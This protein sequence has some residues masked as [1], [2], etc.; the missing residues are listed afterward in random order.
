M[1]DNFKRHAYRVYSDGTESGSSPFTGENPTLPV[2]MTASNL[3][4]IYHYREGIAAYDTVNPLGGTTLTLNAQLEYAVNTGG[5]YGAWANVNAS[6][7]YVRSAASGSLTDGGNTTNRGT[8]GISDP[9]QP[10]TTLIFKGTAQTDEVDGL[11]AGLA[12]THSPLQEPP[13]LD[14]TEVLF[15]FTFRSAEITVSGTKIKLRVTDAG[16]AF[17]AGTPANDVEFEFTLASTRRIFIIS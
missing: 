17:D 15:S 14:F 3:N 5:G 1:P 9:N 10:D 11:C 13:E 16:V 7:S 2:A 4:V 6:S 12:L 8:N